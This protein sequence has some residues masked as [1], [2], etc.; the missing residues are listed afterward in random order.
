MPRYIDVDKLILSMRK[1]VVDEQS[2]KASTS[3]VE[4]C[5]AFIDEIEDL[6][7]DDKEDVAPLIHAYWEKWQKDMLRCSTCNGFY[8]PTED[9]YDYKYCS[10]CGAKMDKKGD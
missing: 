2:K 6:L 10:R 4:A 1:C 9:I 8:I 5:E 7:V 3:W